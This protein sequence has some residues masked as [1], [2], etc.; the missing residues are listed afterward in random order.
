MTDPV[1]EQ[2]GDL[3]LIADDDRDIVRFVEVNLSL[4]GFGWRLPPTATTPW[5]RPCRSCPT[6]SCLST[7]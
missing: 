2:G 7:G 5:P 1:S 3:V 6:W 4:E